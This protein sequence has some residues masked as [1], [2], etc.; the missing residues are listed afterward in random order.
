[1][2]SELEKEAVAHIMPVGS[3]LVFVV[4]NLV[5][6]SRQTLGSSSET[7]G[8]LVVEMVEQTLDQTDTM[9]SFPS[10]CLILFQSSPTLVPRPW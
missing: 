7:F 8:A 10:P 5:G 3:G 1:M 2:G 4:R 9:I 6:I